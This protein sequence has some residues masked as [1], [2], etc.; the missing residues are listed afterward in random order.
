[1]QTAVFTEHQPAYRYMLVDDNRADV[2]IYK[3][4]RNYKTEE[5]NDVAYV[6][7]FKSFSV[8]PTAIT[9]AMIA[10]N[11]LDYIEYE[12]STE[13]TKTSDERI[14]ELESTVTDLQMALCDMFENM[15][16]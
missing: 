4:L 1:M 12:P 7:Q 5:S 2:F 14:T 9:E 15:E 3:Y 8:E 10:E 6:Y 16:G 11:P 13:S